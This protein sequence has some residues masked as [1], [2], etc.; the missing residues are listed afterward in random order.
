M[1]NLWTTDPLNYIPREA[2]YEMRTPTRVLALDDTDMN[3]TVYTSEPDHLRLMP[4]TYEH[5]FYDGK[6]YGMFAMS[7]D[8]LAS[9]ILSQS[10]F[11]NSEEFKN[12]IYIASVCDAINQSR[13]TQQPVTIPHE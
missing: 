13:L 9:S 5:Y 11:D 10:S 7:V 8:S 4:D 1:E 2:S 3:V 6:P 12:A